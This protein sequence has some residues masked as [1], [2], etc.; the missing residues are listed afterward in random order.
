MNYS[1]Q[2]KDVAQI[3]RSHG[4]HT[5]LFKLMANND[6]SK[7]QVY[8]G[9]DF[10]ILRNVP[11]G[12]IYEDG[13]SE[14]KGA[15]FKA[16]VSLSWIDLNDNIQQASGSQFILYPKYPEVRLSGLLKGCGLAPSHLMQPPTPEEREQRLAGNLNRCLV[17]GICQNSVLAYV[18]PWD[19]ALSR[20]AAHRIDSGESELFTSVFYEYSETLSK[21]PTRT[22]LIQRLNEIH[23]MGFIRSCRLDA[24]GN[25]I[26]YKAQ[27]G[28]GLT[29]ESFFGITP[30]GKSEPDFL[31]WE[32]KA[33]SSGVVTLMTPEPDMG[34]YLDDFY[35]FLDTYATSRTARKINFA[36]IH[37]MNEPN[38][39]SSLTMTLTGFDYSK[40]EITDPKGGMVL[41]DPQENIAA[42]WSFQKL[43]NH[44]KRKHANTCYVSYQKELR[45]EV[46]YFSYGPNIRL[47]TGANIKSYVS[48]LADS[49]VYYDP[50]I[51]MKLT[52][53]KWKAKKRNQFR[54]KWK[55]VSSI[56]DAT[57]DIVLS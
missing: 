41:M 18:S 50:G 23:H 3:M 8:C 51:N 45:E 7:Q 10:D 43:L 57:E 42:G 13:Y 55:D 49:V 11:T 38:E 44:W 46:P 2:L 48:G 52:N 34:T 24:A 16:K 26:P 4:A 32:L 25:R 39:K 36:S 21:T 22:K 15:I 30:N 47:C 56:Y 35:T 33:H 17:F 31:D 53:S 20:E 6:N 5:V 19:S 37:R 29:L 40:S 54:I 14:K 28:A 9:S 12:D 1:A 27:N